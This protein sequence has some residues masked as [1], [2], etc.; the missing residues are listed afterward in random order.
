MCHICEWD[1]IYNHPLKYGV[2]L[3]ICEWITK[4]FRLLNKYILKSGEAL[5][6]KAANSENKAKRSKIR[7]F[8]AIFETAGTCSRLV[9]NQEFNTWIVLIRVWGSTCHLSTCLSRRT[10]WPFLPPASSFL[11]C[12]SESGSNM[13]KRTWYSCNCIRTDL[14]SLMSV[15]LARLS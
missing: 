8:F 12:L 2:R 10:W 5:F 13:K 4:V 7:I 9:N 6:P 15:L 3:T 11:L 14:L 1:I